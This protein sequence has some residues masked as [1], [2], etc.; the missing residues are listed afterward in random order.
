M[1][2]G[3]NSTKSQIQVPQVA[4]QSKDMGS[5][6][7]SDDEELSTDR[8]LDTYKAEPSVSIDICPL[9]WWS[10]H[11]GAHNN[12]ARIAKKY[13]STPASNVPVWQSGSQWEKG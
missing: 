4:A 7:E 5:E 8:T 2:K 6:S 3:N 10:T 12:L 11:S 9:Q 1:V 13:L